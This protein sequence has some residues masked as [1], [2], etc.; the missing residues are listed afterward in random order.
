[1][2]EIITGE[3]SRFRSNLIDYHRAM[4]V[5]LWDC[6]PEQPRPPERPIAP[7]GVPGDPE[8]DLAV[9]ELHDKLEQYEAELKAYGTA[10]REHEIWWQKNGGP[11]EFQQWS[12]D[13]RDALQHDANAVHEG[14]QSRRRYY[15]SSKT[16]GYQHLENH[17]LPPGV[18]PGRGQDQNLARQAADDQALAVARREDPVFGEGAI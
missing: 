7:K 2:A 9:I 1:M 13:A 10:K 3:F 5:V 18:T 8:Y 6:G 12:C 11:V 15:L 4:Q 16:R 14:R 17:G